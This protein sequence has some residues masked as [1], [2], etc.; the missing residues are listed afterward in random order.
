MIKSTSSR[1]E[2]PTLYLYVFGQI[3]SLSF[4]PLLQEVNTIICH[5]TL[6][7]HLYAFSIVSEHIERD[8]KMLEI[9]LLL[10]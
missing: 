10:L 1:Y 5:N 9:L 6:F 4:I 8:F 7:R 2:S 3:I